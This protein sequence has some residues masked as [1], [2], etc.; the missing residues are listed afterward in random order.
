MTC[1]EKGTIFSTAKAFKYANVWC[2]TEQVRKWVWCVLSAE[3]LHG[4]VSAL[5]GVQR[6]GFYPI[7]L[8]SLS[9]GGFELPGVDVSGHAGVCWGRPNSSRFPKPYPLLLEGWGGGGSFKDPWKFEGLDIYKS[10]FWISIDV[11]V[12]S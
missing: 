1:K 10:R 2:L 11:G 5:V 6:P 8:C 12:K 9:T 7:A 3:V 4:F